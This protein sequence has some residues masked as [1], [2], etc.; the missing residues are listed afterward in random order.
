MSLHYLIM[1]AAVWRLYRW[2]LGGRRRA[3]RR[4]SER[5][6]LVAL[7]SDAVLFSGLAYR[8]HRRKAAAGRATAPRDRRV[9]TWTRKVDL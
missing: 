4:P 6:W 7:V 1:A 2:K 3:A 5:P 8:E 9:S